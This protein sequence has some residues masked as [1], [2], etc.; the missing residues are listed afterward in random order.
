MGKHC[1]ERPAGKTESRSSFSF[2]DSVLGRRAGSLFRVFEVLGLRF[3]YSSVLI[4][5]F[6][7]AAP[8]NVS[9]GVSAKCGYF[10]Q[11]CKWKT[12]IWR[13]LYWHWRNSRLQAQPAVWW[14]FVHKKCIS[15]HSCSYKRSRKRHSLTRKH[16]KEITNELTQLI[17]RFMKNKT[18]NQITSSKSP[19]LP[20]WRT[21]VIKLCVVKP[22]VYNT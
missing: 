20:A 3:G 1:Q 22:E 8:T 21:Y 11:L 16:K 9:N 7:S 18:I 14:L 12:R 5:L 19:C 4:W 6:L 2:T 17:S 15:K 10:L 13:K